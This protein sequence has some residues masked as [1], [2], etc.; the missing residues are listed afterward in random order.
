M[1]VARR[2]VRGCV[3]ELQPA[4]ALARPRRRFTQAG[5]GG[6]EDMRV[7]LTKKGD[8]QRGS[9]V[10]DERVSLPTPM[11][12]TVTIRCKDRK[13]S[14]DFYNSMFDFETLHCH[15]CKE[16]GFTLLYTGPREDLRCIPPRARFDLSRKV[17]KKESWQY[18]EQNRK[19][20]TGSKKYRPQ[21]GTMDAH[22]YLYHFH[23]TCM[24][25]V[26]L[27]DQKMD[28]TFKVSSGNDPPHLGFGGISVQ[29][30]SL[31]ET[32]RRLQQ[33]NVP[34]L[35]EPTA[36]DPSV[37]VRDP[38]GY[39]VRLYERVPAAVYDGREPGSLSP[40]CLGACRLR[41]RDPRVACVFYERFFGMRLVCR[42]T[43]PDLGLTRY[44]LL[45]LPQL[46]ADL[47][48]TAAPLPT[49][50]DSDSAWEF[51]Q[52]IR[53]CFLE[54]QHHHGTEDRSD[55][56]YHSGNTPPVGFAH[57]GFMVED[58]ESLVKSMSDQGVF[59]IKNL[60]EGTFPQ[61][62][63]VMDPDGYWLELYP[64]GMRD[65]IIS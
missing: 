3:A 53:H 17:D 4:S 22:D 19:I 56:Q 41:V 60:G 5:T 40:S 62:A 29:V 43:H 1:R 30:D 37:L 6:L 33:R 11:L 47:R 10:P 25:L 55:I 51:V 23:M 45:C 7:Q 49:E 50:V 63:L 34:L 35:G 12:H 52:S 64:F 2:H 9:M 21:L 14:A 20:V 46:M 27:H 38:D 15:V 16:L 42:R 57:L 39:G 18:Q 36:D 59:V 26:E 58:P 54:L 61:C 32:C 28:Y 44:Y 13:L 65:T 8:E 31:R 24:E 48:S